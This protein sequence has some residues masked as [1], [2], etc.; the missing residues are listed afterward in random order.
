MKSLKF[1]ITRNAHVL[2]AITLIS[3][4]V[5]S[6]VSFR[7]AT[8]GSLAPSAVPAVGSYSLQDVFNRL[9][10]NTSATAGNHAFAPTTTPVSTFPTLTQ[11]FNAIPTIYPSDFLA[12]STY[13]GVTG[14]IAVKTGNTAVASSSAQGTSLV[15]TIPT[16][17]YSGANSV[18]V[19]TSSNSFIASNIK[20]GVNL[21]GV[22][23]NITTIDYSLQEL[24]TIDDWVC[25]GA[26]SCTS[27]T[28][29]EYTAEESTWA[30][31]SGS[32]FAG[33]DSINFSAGG[34][35]WN[36][37]SGTVKQDDRTGLMWSDAA[38]TTSPAGALV[39]SSTSNVF[40][41]TGTAG[42][43]DGTRP[44]GGNAIGFCDALNSASFGGYT[45][46]YLPT[47]K[48]LMQAYIDGSANNLSSPGFYFWSSTES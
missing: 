34:A 4:S 11:I 45:D 14:S 23:G 6:L 12:S 47:Q 48:Q 38:A 29:V 26:T 7:T 16:G 36:L 17:Y 2:F 27:P 8:A 31:V 24:Q 33:Y 3:L 22:D 35:S 42:V 28:R 39:A 25:S 21:F 44:T 41:L 32:P 10:T 18:T 5:A 46:W 40:T 13:L 20:S 15:F 9:L 37:V 30:T 1:R 43:G 19:A